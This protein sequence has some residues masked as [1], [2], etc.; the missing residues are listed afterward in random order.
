M[1]QKKLVSVFQ[2]HGVVLAYRFGSSAHGKKG[3]LSDTDIAVLFAA[4]K[5]PKGFAFDILSDLQEIFPDADLTILNQAPPLLRHLVATDGKLLYEAEMNINHQFASKALK[6]YEDTR[7]LRQVFMQSVK[8][9]VT[10]EYQ[11]A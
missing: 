2:K 6:D 3:P 10:H 4:G 1:K 11:T 7:Y 8:E 5:E 9:R